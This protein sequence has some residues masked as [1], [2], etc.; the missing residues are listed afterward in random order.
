M[1][2]IFEYAVHITFCPASWIWDIF[3]RFSLDIILWIKKK[4]IEKEKKKHT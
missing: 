1:Q 3:G 4:K 2:M